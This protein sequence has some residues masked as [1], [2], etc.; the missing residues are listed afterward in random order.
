MSDVKQYVTGCLCW[1]TNK[2][3]V[4]FNQDDELLTAEFLSKCKCSRHPDILSKDCWSKSLSKKEILDLRSK[5]YSG[6]FGDRV[7]YLN[8]KTEKS[9]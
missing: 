7:F 6:Y 1:L 2:I 5:I 4:N 9:N 3:D 8:D